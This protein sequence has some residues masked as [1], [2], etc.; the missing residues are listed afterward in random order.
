MTGYR[1]AALTLLE[2]QPVDGPRLTLRVRARAALRDVEGLRKDLVTSSRL[3]A[4]SRS[5]CAR[6]T[7]RCVA[8]LGPRRRGA[9][10]RNA[11]R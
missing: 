5:S 8:T 9:R 4:S 2:A 7:P 1:R 11:L 10:P 6:A 3:D